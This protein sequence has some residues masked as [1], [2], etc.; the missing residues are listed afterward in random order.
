[1]VGKKEELAE[2]RRRRRVGHR[3]SRC[4]G[5]MHD[6]FPLLSWNAFPTSSGL[7]AVDASRS[8]ASRVLRERD[9]Q[10]RVS[11]CFSTPST[12]APSPWPD[13]LY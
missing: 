7:S 9:R 13:Y 2:A 3:R 6:V 1:M 10:A 5:M 11:E 12:I 8:P 4:F